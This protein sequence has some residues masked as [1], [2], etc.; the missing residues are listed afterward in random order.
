[1]K[2]L[3]VCLVLVAALALPAQASAR[4]REY[5][6][7]ITPSGELGF[8]VKSKKGKKPKVKGFTF[9]DVPIN[10]AEGPNTTFGAITGGVKLRKKRFSAEVSDKETGQ[11]HLEVAGTVSKRSANGTIRVSGSSPLQDPPTDPPIRGTNCD[12][13]V[14]SWTVSRT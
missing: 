9:R 3:L 1:V 13:G 2:R 4:Q 11:S 12:T 14:L 6:G 10:C 5:D 7:T 8:K